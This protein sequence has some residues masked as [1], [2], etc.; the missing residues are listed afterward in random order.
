VGHF[1]TGLDSIGESFTLARHFRGQ[2]ARGEKLLANRE[3]VVG[4]VREAAVGGE[5]TFDQLASGAKSIVFGISNPRSA[6]VHAGD[7]CVEGQRL[8][9]VVNWVF[10][11]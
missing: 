10:G 2:Q 8:P 1:S 11:V 7:R 6:C 5:K 9:E 4:P 3:K